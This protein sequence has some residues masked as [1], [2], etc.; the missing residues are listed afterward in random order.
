[1]DNKVAL[2]M[3]K[4]NCCAGKTSFPCLTGVCEHQ[5]PLSVL[6]EVLPSSMFSKVSVRFL[7]SLFK[8][9]HL[10]HCFIIHKHHK[11][12]LCMCSSPSHTPNTF[13]RRVPQNIQTHAICWIALGSDGVVP[14]CPHLNIYMS[15]SL[16]VRVR[17]G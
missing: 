11:R 1:M 10:L 2:T 16:C 17:L 15:A 9:P 13:A 12:V 3:A 4:L 6:K 7:L 8:S 14:V 5:I